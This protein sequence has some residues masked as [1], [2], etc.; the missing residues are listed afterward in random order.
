[1]IKYLF[2]L[3]S[4]LNFS[5]LMSQSNDVLVGVNSSF[6]SEKQSLYTY[7]LKDNLISN[8]HIF[9][10]T[11]PLSG[12]IS[13]EF[14]KIGS[15]FY[16]L[17][18]QS[19]DYPNGLIYSYDELTEKYK[20]EK[21][22]SGTNG[23]LPCGNLTLAVNG[24]IYGLTSKG[25]LHNVGV[26]FEFDIEQ[27]VLSVVHHF[28][29]I[30]GR[31][32]I[33]ISA[34]ISSLVEISD[35]VL[36]GVTTKGGDSDVGVMYK[37]DLN[38]NVFTK[39][40]D[41]STQIGYYPNNYLIK[42]DNYI[43]GTTNMASINDNGI[44]FKYSINDNQLSILNY[45]N[46][47]SLESKFYL[48]KSNILL[49]D[50]QTNRGLLKYDLNNM[51]SEDVLQNVYANYIEYDSISNKLFIYDGTTFY[52]QKGIIY[53]FNLN[54][55]RIDDT[56]VIDAPYFGGECTSLKY[57]EILDK[58]YFVNTSG[59][60]SINILDKNVQKIPS[61]K[62]ND[63]R[64]F[65]KI[66]TEN[67]IAISNVNGY[68]S[69]LKLENSVI[70]VKST[71]NQYLKGNGVMYSP[72]LAG[73]GKM[74]GITKYG[75][76]FNNGVLYEFDPFSNEF[77]VKVNFKDEFGIE[78]IT[79][80]CLSKN[81]KIY[82]ATSKGGVFGDGTFFSFEPNSEEFKVI[83]NYNNVDGFYYPLF[84]F[85]NE[86]QTFQ[87]FNFNINFG[88]I[89]SYYYDENR[90][91]YSINKIYNNPDAFMDYIVKSKVSDK[92]YF[93][94]T[95]YNQTNT[96]ILFEFDSQKKIFSE[97]RKFKQEEVM[98][99]LPNSLVTDNEGNLYF[100]SYHSG[101]YNKGSLFKF[102]TSN[103]EL[104]KLYDFNPAD[105]MTT[106]TLEFH[107]HYLYGAIMNSNNYIND[108]KIFKFNLQT[109]EYN[110]IYSYQNEITPYFGFKYISLDDLLT[111]SENYIYPNPVNSE[112]FIELEN[113]SEISVYDQLGNQLMN[114]KGYKG[115]NFIS[116][117]G[118][119][120]GIYMIKTDNQKSKFVKY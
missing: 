71:F 8:E 75:G 73:N 3:I 20:V 51:T 37:F 23:S 5:F 88:R 42:K 101:F 14:I 2:V 36:L 84:I 97:I 25:G 63:T 82:G 106:S 114:K 109:L 111:P 49:F 77:A 30:N 78:P 94:S 98:S 104:V 10:I 38:Q 65:Q 86:F 96:G 83:L 119:A 85:E 43:Y 24:K 35:N 60:Y 76:T 58:I 107:D 91:E 112:L 29:I 116:V 100:S 80:L 41:F 115:R 17:S 46:V 72:I 120:N 21:S 34:Q 27:N 87:L 79:Q 33:S 59:I 7:S 92:Y 1:M 95:L 66:S 54:S 44:I 45:S 64:I 68:L 102:N 16:W 67:Y 69:L 26:I 61:F 40:F 50:Y 110:D 90:N 74:Y 105:N 31:N 99:V 57:D 108:E 62:V 28:D 9:G 117:D 18:S 22:F 13:S 53:D 48:T 19:V 39:L 70:S 4:L 56:L 81:G 103:G 118:F 113:D 89:V 47:Y 32:D 15:K 6:V 93:L 52:N 11:N 55:N 12:Q